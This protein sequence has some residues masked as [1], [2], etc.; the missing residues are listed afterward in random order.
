MP[1]LL[2]LEYALYNDVDNSDVVKMLLEK[3]ADYNVNDD[4]SYIVYS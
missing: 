2:A 1:L 3:G 4:V